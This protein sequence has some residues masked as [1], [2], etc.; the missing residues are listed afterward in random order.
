MKIMTMLAKFYT[1][2]LTT[3]TAT[4]TMFESILD[5]YGFPILVVICAFWYINK[6]QEE[7]R[8]DYNAL[9]KTHEE[10]VKSLTAALNSN[11]EILSRLRDT[12]EDMT[13]DKGGHVQ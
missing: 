2:Y 3:A 7:Y 12:L 11:T 10:E 6:I 4:V 13:W 5:K 9:H 1:P 8:E